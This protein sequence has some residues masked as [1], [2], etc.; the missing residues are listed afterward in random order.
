MI[1]FWF[2]TFWNLS[3]TDEQEGSFW[4]YTSSYPPLLKLFSTPPITFGI[5]CHKQCVPTS[6]RQLYRP[7]ASLLF[8]KFG[9]REPTPSLRN[10]IVSFI[11][12]FIPPVFVANFLRMQALVIPRWLC[13][14]SCPQSWAVF[15]KLKSKSKVTTPCR[16]SCLW[17]KETGGGYIEEDIQHSRLMGRDDPKKG[18]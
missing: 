1:C 18:F 2:C 11:C 12:P 15:D 3:T 14:V 9:K 17:H 7:V 8:D 5:K 16:P 4:T 13:H 6:Q 10:S